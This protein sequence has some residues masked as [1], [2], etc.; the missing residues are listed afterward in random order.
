MHQIGEMF[1]FGDM[2]WHGL[3]E[4]LPR[5]ATL[6]EAIKAGRLDWDVELVPLATD[7]K[8]ATRAPQRMAVA[9][10]DRRPGDAGRVLGVVH[11]GFRPL[12]NREGAAIFN[13]LFDAGGRKYHTGGWLRNGEVVW[14]QAKLPATITVGGDDL[15]EPYL[16]FSNSHDGSQAIDIRITTVRVVC[17]NTLS[18]ALGKQHTGLVFHHRHRE[19]SEMLERYAATFF[20][21]VLQRVREVEEVMRKLAAI[22]VDAAQFARF[23][24]QVLPDPPRPAATEANPT[25]A[26]A[27]AT[28]LE[29]LRIA[30]EA[31]ARIRD[32]GIP[33]REIPPEAPTWWGS[34]NAVTAWA[35]HVQPVDGDRFAHATFGSGRR[36]KAAV[37]DAAYAMASGRDVSAG[38]R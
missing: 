35:D 11:P 25:V 24:R 21:H 5:P 38:N 6:D 29:N 10:C 8:P 13:R 23:L 30:R 31:I 18:H 4:P 12:Q 14:L 34:V 17:R 22:A 27:H 2:P 9:R 37:F 16:L 33:E 19:K 36:F 26:K 3:G 28:R 7:E 1:W 15:V 20:T 32:Q